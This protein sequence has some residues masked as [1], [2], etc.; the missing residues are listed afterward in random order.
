MTASEERLAPLT[1]DAALAEAEDLVADG[2]H[3]V[4]IDLLEAADGRRPD[5][6]IEARL[7]ELRHLAFE[8]MAPV[9]RADWPPA[10]EDPGSG[11]WGPPECT[12]DELTPS[13]LAGALVHR[14]SLLVRGLLDVGQA[15]RMRTVLHR[16]STARQQLQRGGAGPAA[17]RWYRPFELVPDTTRFGQAHFVRAVDSPRGLHQ[18]LATYREVGV[19]DVI[20]EHLG[21]RPAASAAKLAFRRLPPGWVAEDFHQDGRFLGADIRTVNV[22]TALTPCGGPDGDAPALDLVA[23]RIEGIV[24]TG[25]EGTAFE[26]TVSPAQAEELAG[27]QGIVRPAFE[28]G[29]ALLFDQL[30]LHRTGM[31][32]DMTGTREAIE[33]WFF[34]P[35]AYPVD[36][37]PVVI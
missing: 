4:A 9:P 6:R 14:G 25:G 17:V 34:A 1:A 23:R 7:V 11:P 29:D 19:L 27:A 21:E 8:Q 26:W 15:Q 36:G 32:A 16:A 28:P 35:S 30:L 31:S 10:G 24:P 33:S 3:L 20:A 37:I 13:V 2:A 12:V 18:L 5:E 22:W